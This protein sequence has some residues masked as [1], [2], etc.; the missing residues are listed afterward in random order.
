MGCIEYARQLLNKDWLRVHWTINENK[1][2]IDEKVLWYVNIREE[3]L[4]YRRAVKCLEIQTLFGHNYEIR[5]EY[6]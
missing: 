3:S 6:W 5:E 2:L 1:T 4:E